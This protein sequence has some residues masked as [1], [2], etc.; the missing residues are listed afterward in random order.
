M[1]SKVLKEYV[2]KENAN[3]LQAS[4][5]EKLPLKFDETAKI[6][7]LLH[8]LLSNRKNKNEILE[9]IQLN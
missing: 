2:K 7:N 5:T 8:D 9:Q 4:F 3:E 6:D 1:E